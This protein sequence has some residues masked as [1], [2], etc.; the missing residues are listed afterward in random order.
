MQ[1]WDHPAMAW[2]GRFLDQQPWHHD[3]VDPLLE[4]FDMPIMIDMP[5]VSADVPRADA[6]LITHTDND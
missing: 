1:A 6:I 5:I 3:H 2:D 4:G